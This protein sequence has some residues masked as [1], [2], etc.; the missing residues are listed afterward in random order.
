MPLTTKGKEILAAMRKQYGAKKGKS[1]FYASANAG[2]ITGVHSPDRYV[3]DS[4]YGERPGRTE[5]HTRQDTAPGNLPA[6][7]GMPDVQ[8][9]DA[10][11]SLR[12]ETKTM[13][14]PAE[15]APQA[16]KDNW[17]S[18]VDSFSDSDV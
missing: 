2:K 13:Q 3:D 6:A 15:K 18:G 4:P 17:P 7:H 12:A 10:S 16:A 1:V 14:V 5:Y 11:A 8:K 9:N